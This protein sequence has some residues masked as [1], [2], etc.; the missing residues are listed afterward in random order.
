V[1][2]VG[3]SEAVTVVLERVL[4]PPFAGSFAGW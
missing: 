2:Y 4:G 1:L 3:E